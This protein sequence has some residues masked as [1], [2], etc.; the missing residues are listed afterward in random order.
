MN[1]PLEKIKKNL[2]QLSNENTMKTYPLYSG[3]ELCLI[4]LRTEQIALQHKEL[5]HIL[6]INYC[7]D[8][9]VGWNMG[10]GNTVYL[11]PH[12]YSMHTMKTCAKSVMTLPNQYYKGLILCIDLEQITKNPPELLKETGITGTFLY[13]KFCTNEAFLSFAGNRNTETIFSAFFHQPKELQSTYWKIKT[14]ELLLYLSKLEIS[15]R[16]CLSEYQSEQIKIVRTIHEQMAQ[17]LDQRFT[18]EFLSKQYLM[19]PTTLKQVFKAVYGNSIAAHIKE[20][21]MERAAELLLETNYSI[22]QISKI[23]GY[24]SQSKFTSAF[25]EQ[26]HTLPTDY[27]KHH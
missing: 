9:R 5:D 19:N 12:D 4:E 20:H 27:R 23:V 15:S 7:Y 16:Q 8:G 26:F 13:N 22:A 24:D 21:R 2:E 6:E 1:H 10:N 17:H 3:I 11:G 25:K 14:V 18:I